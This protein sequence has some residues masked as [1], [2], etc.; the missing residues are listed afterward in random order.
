MLSASFRFCLALRLHWHWLGQ[1]GVQKCI[2]TL[3][4]SIFIIQQA[5]VFPELPTRVFDEVA[6]SSMDCFCYTASLIPIP[7]SKRHVQGNLDAVVPEHL[8]SERTMMFLCTSPTISRG[9]GKR[10]IVEEALHRRLQLRK[11]QAFVCGHHSDELQT[12]F[13]NL[14]NSN[15]IAQDEACA[16]FANEEFAGVNDE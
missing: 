14:E 4:S 2:Y 16:G 15:R 1:P 12:R 5:T 6:L 3:R 8:P 7:A 13:A 11:C 10:R 9:Y